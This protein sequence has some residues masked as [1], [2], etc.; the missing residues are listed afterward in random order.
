[1]SAPANRQGTT[2][3]VQMAREGVGNGAT[4]R[5]K[6]LRSHHLKNLGPVA[7]TNQ[8]YSGH[9]S[10]EVANIETIRLTFE[11]LAQYL[12]LHA[13]NMPNCHSLNT[14]HRVNRKVM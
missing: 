1:M 7:L 3:A 11:L 10:V 4:T 12:N 6:R 8:S 9:P 5:A 2:K 14:R 13:Q